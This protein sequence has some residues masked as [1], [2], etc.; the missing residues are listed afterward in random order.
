MQYWY[1]RRCLC[2]FPALSAISLFIIHCKLTVYHDQTQPKITKILS[3]NKGVSA[4]EHLV[5]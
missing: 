3:Y 5:L 1:H 2:S 4:I